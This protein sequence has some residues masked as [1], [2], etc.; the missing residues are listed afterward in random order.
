MKQGK[1]ILDIV[2][3]VLIILL[4]KINITGSKLHEIFG[5]I[6]FILFLFHKIL[7]LLKQY[8]QIY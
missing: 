7:N 6:I 1:V 8:G 2:M 5:I 3:L 4:M